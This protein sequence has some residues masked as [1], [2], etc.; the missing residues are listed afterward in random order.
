MT[1]LHEVIFTCSLLIY[2]TGILSPRPS[3]TVTESIKQNKQ[4][5]AEFASI[6]IYIGIARFPCD[7]TAF[8][9]YSCGNFRLGNTDFNFFT[10]SLQQEIWVMIMKYKHNVCH[11]IFFC[12]QHIWQKIKRVSAF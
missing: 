5:P 4:L 12:D 1:D 2:C 9:S 3:S 8:L 10:V 6:E 11:L 7:S